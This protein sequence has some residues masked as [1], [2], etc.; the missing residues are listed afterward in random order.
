MFILVADERFFLMAEQFGTIYVFF[1]VWTFVQLLADQCYACP[2]VF[3]V[4]CS[5][6]AKFFFFLEICN[7]DIFCAESGRSGLQEVEVLAEVEG[8]DDDAYR[9][10]VL[11]KEE[12]HADA[13]GL[14]VGSDAAHGSDGHAIVVSDVGIN[15]CEQRYNEDESE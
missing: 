11:H 15:R 9:Q 4:Y 5:F 3:E 13:D 7:Q 2:E 10:D 1:N 14:A 8:H 12:C 6:V